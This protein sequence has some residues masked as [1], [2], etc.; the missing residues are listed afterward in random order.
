[1]APEATAPKTTQPS[2]KKQRDKPPKRN[3]SEKL[4]KKLDAFPDKIDV[5]DWFYEPSLK[6]LPDQLIN[7]DCVPTILDQ[8][9]EGACTGFA[10]AAVINYHLVK[11]GRC[12]KEVIDKEGVSPRMLY[13]MARRYDEWPGEE[14]EGSSARGT[15]KGWNA[16]GVVKDWLWTGEM[17]GPTHLNDELAKEAL[18][19]PVGA[20]YRVMHRQVRDMHAALHEAGILYATLMVHAGWQNP[21]KPEKTYLYKRDGTNKE[22]KL[23]VIQRKD[24]A[25]GGHAVAIVGYTRD[26]FIIQ[27]SWGSEWGNDGFALLPYED[28]ML[29]ASDCWVVQLGVPIEVDLWKNGLNADTSAGKQR[30]SQVIPLEEVRPYVIN[31]GNNGFLSDSGDYWTT[32]KDIERLFQSIYNVAQ[33]GKW[34]KKRI[35]LYL[36]GGLNSETAVARRIISFKEVCLQNEIY[37]VHIMW[38]TD[39]WNSLK[40]SV[41][42]IFTNDDRAS[43]NW[44]QKLREATLEIKDRTFELTA[45]KPGTMLWDEMKENAQLA[46]KRPSHKDEKKRA[47]TIVADKGLEAYQSLADEEKQNWEIHI[48]A[49]S[50]GS[51]FTAY[52][53]ETLMG[54]GIPVK[55][56]QFMAPAISVKL[57]KEKFFPL[58]AKNDAL[59]PTI[60]LLSDKGERDDDVSAYGKSL[61]YLVSN[62]FERKRGTAILGMEKFV[63]SENKELDEEDIDEEVA[64]MLRK[65]INGW[66]SLVVS[67]A[68]DA[69]K[70]SGPD[71]SRSETHGGFDN[72]TYT[73]NSVMYRILNRKP[74]REFETR[75]LQF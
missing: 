49:H 7:C 11:N 36:H 58:V 30:A 61:L 42:D 22:I 70:K 12:G 39:F 2:A 24:R 54:I 60:Y 23:P 1:M 48:V 43:A 20:Y 65:K 75:D 62:A 10:L 13:E 15:M 18:A 27:N 57:F 56:V 51:I 9:H 8:K 41:F 46:S 5:R 67:G 38:E 16:H 69:K 66:P 74:K 63:N 35:M 40:S 37:P 53:L 6:P 14:Y 3:T 55:S 68:A 59:R 28:W 31:I 52:A 21:G 19:V 26:G 47:I 29:H 45:S 64:A 44:L 73:L 72:D 25:D 71:I 32:E 4:N 17:K 50:A 33:K 34:E